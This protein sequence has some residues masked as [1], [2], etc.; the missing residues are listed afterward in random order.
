M[1]DVNSGG[2]SVSI[3]RFHSAHL[4]QAHAQADTPTVDGIYFANI[5]LPILKDFLIF[6]IK[7]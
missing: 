1:R 6:L 4:A 3:L 2:P 5:F 7:Y